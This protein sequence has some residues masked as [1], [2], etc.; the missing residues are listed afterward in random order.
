MSNWDGGNKRE[1]SETWGE[2][3]RE[4][5]GRRGKQSG[6]LNGVLV[7][8]VGHQVT[9]P[10]DG[11]KASVCTQTMSSQPS[12]PPLPPSHHPPLLPPS[13][14]P[15]LLHSIAIFSPRLVWLHPSPA[16]SPAQASS[17]YLSICLLVTPFYM[18]FIRMTT[19]HHIPW[20]IIS[21]IP[22]PN[23]VKSYKVWQSIS[24]WH[25]LLLFFFHIS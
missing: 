2:R 1:V 13:K 24:V 15:F 25:F 4:R 3:S 19:S 7:G 23:C 22:T 5:G 16:Y 17:P 10:T 18:A 6:D 21:V 9:L 20:Q 14:S 8:A 12:R 11:K